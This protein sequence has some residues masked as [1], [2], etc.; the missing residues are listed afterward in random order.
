M[1]F[2]LRKNRG[3]PVKE[4]GKEG[5]ERSLVKMREE[6]EEEDEEERSEETKETTMGDDAVAA[7][8]RCGRLYQF[9][10]KLQSYLSVSIG[11]SSVLP[12]SSKWLFHP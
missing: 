10:V 9:I 8:L 3:F 11:H 6:Q 12:H 2:P 1:S 5:E 4:I 7:I